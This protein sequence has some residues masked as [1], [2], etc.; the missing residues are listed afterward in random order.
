MVTSRRALDA[1]LVLDDLT[2]REDHCL[3]VRDGMPTCTHV[4]QSVC[5]QVPYDMHTQTGTYFGECAQVSAQ[6]DK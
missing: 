6:E 3:C 5:L 4:A 1:A 2:T